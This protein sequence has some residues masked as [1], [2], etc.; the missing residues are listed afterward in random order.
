MPTFTGTTGNDTLTAT[1]DADIIIAGGGIGS[2]ADV[3]QAF[4]ATGSG[5]IRY[6][7]SGGNL[8]VQADLDGNGTVDMEFIL[9][10]AAAQTLSTANF[11][12]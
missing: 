7:V 10:G 12:F 5:E 2:T 9:Q 8:L 1:G 11:M 3:I 4:S 6:G